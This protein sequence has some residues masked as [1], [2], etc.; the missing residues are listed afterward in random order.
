MKLLKEEAKHTGIKINSTAKAIKLPKQLRPIPFADDP[1]G[2]FD[3]ATHDDEAGFLQ[4]LEDRNPVFISWLHA[5]FFMEAHSAAP[6]ADRQ[7][8]VNR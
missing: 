3:P 1:A 4:D 6:I 8:L 7:V 5:R 2:R